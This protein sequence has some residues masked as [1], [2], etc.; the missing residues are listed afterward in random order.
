MSIV[1]RISEMTPLDEVANI[2]FH[3]FDVGES[4]TIYGKDVAIFRNEISF[5]GAEGAVY[6]R[7]MIVL[8]F[9]KSIDFMENFKNGKRI[10]KEMPNSIGGAIP[11][12]IFRWKKRTLENG[13][14][15]YMIWR[16]V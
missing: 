6:D 7:G 14:V 11:N 13:Q 3:R 10:Q 16:L 12:K 4:C 9:M 5:G 1:R 8:E 15:A 2:I